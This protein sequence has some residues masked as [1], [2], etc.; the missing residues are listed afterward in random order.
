MP[1][2]QVSTQFTPGEWGNEQS[3]P[4]QSTAEAV[5]LCVA[6]LLHG[7]V[8]I[9]FPNRKITLNNSEKCSSAF[10]RRM[11]GHEGRAG[12]EATPS[13]ANPTSSAG[14]HAQGFAGQSSTQL[15]LVLELCDLRR[16]ACKASPLLGTS[17]H[18]HEP[19]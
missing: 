6:L 2:Y 10:K 12:L 15:C 9:A 5:L 14:A 16:R 19:T 18:S 4:L 13:P 17:A 8:D 3:L 7:F 11:A 1:N